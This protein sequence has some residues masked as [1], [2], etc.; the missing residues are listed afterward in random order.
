MK[1]DERTRV[2]Q[3]L[4]LEVGQQ[5]VLSAYLIQSFIP[6]SFYLIF[7]DVEVQEAGQYL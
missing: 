6:R 1:R 2:D 4:Y 3:L 7:T 5:V